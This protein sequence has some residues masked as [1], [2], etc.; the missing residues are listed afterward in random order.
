MGVEHAAVPLPRRH[1]IASRAAGSLFALCLALTAC[2]AAL[3]LRNGTGV[4]DLAFLLAVTC[5]AVV[6]QVIASHRPANP[7]GFFF[8]LSAL[9]FAVT[10][11]SAE[12]AKYGLTTDPGSLSAAS[13]M[14]WLSAWMWVPGAVLVLVLVP[15]H[16]PDGRL[17]S[18][19]WRPVAWFA[20]LF[21]V[22][23]AAVSAVE[24]GPFAGSHL[25]N[26]WGAPLPAGPQQPATWSSCPYGWALWP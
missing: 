8:L 15:L 17:A 26:P 2:A 22:L 3:G 25:V 5:S 11:F 9:S 24:P 20:V 18:P 1:R 19:R 7:I 4:E 10:A 23:M 12:Y 14:V 21:G 16:F 13:T 6:G